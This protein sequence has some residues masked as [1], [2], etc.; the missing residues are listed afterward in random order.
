M[1]DIASSLEKEFADQSQSERDAYIAHL[2]ELEAKGQGSL[3]VRPHSIVLASLFILIGVLMAWALGTQGTNITA[4][5][6]GILIGVAVAG[7]GAWAM[8]WPRKP[9]FTLTE[10]GVRVKGE[11][12]PWSSIEDYNVTIHSTNSVPTHISVV[13]SHVAGF[14]PPKGVPQA[15]RGGLIG[16]MRAA[17]DSEPEYNTNLMLWTGAKGMSADQLTQRIHD[18]LT[19]ARAKEELARLQA[20]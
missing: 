15:R 9:K 11:L 1:S 17:K 2:K 13:L 10:E 3:D 14:K 6:I 12:L 20:G 8:L 18:F 4:S 16:K 19:A 7:W 5:I